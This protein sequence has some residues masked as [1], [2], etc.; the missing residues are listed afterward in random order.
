MN[1]Q[2]LCK[3][4]KFTVA[5]FLVTLIFSSCRTRKGTSTS[6]G[7]TNE[8]RPMKERSIDELMDRLDSSSFRP[9][10]MNAKASV[11][12]IVDSNETSFTIHL[13]GKRDSAIWI[14]ITPLLGIEV[15]RILITTDS[16]KVLDRLHGKFQASSFEYINRL[17]QMKVNFETVQALLCG[18][19][20]A[21][22]KN[23]N[24]FNSV[25]LE[26]KYYILSSLTK[27][28]LKRSL[29][30]KDPNKAVI[31]DCYIDN[32]NYRITKVTVDDQKIKKTL[33]TT[34]EDFRLADGSMFPFRSH[35][36]ITAE[37]NFEIT[38]AYSKV[39]TGEPQELPFN[40]PKSYERMH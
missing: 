40:I 30:E 28:K 18:N 22:K 8:I 4:M 15:A 13:R 39:E 32:I 37:K 14:S 31:Q 26:D 19:F 3:G 9:E 16:V 20:F 21:Y 34:Y 6:A 11:T 24:K 25:Y 2:T 1:R 38:I 10:W 12:T 27:H 7:T 29:E 35:T 23:E 36:T 33:E 17:L 5:F